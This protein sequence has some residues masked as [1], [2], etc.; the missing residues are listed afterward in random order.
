M[1]NNGLSVLVRTE[2]EFN[3]MVEF[4]GPKLLYLHW[5][6]QMGEVETA[7]VI[8]Y[9]DTKFMSIGSVGSADYQ[10]KFGVRVVEFSDFFK[11]TS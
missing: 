7:I 10:K 11:L 1:E 6:P 8:D 2:E 5:V 3:R 9:S 4:L